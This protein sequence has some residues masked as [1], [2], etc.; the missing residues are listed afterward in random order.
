[1]P[2][3]ADEGAFIVERLMGDHRRAGVVLR[4]GQWLAESD[5]M[6]GRH[7]L[8]FENAEQVRQAIK[9]LPVRHI[10]IDGSAALRP[11][12]RLLQE[13]V[14]GDPADFRLVGRFP[15][16][17]S[18]GPGRG[19]SR[20]MNTRRRA[21]GVPRL[22]KFAWAWSGMGGYWNIAGRPPRHKLDC[23]MPPGPER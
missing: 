4:A 22:S 2:Y 1:M 10:V 17:E 11:D 13:A 23:I 8:L 18:P 15:I 12:Q 7:R 16:S 19:T 3:P 21:R 14:T 6:G 9:A 5:W 20:F